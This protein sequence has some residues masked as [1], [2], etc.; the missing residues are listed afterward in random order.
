[1]SCVVI[2][3]GLLY[4]LLL[5]LLSMLLF[6]FQCISASYAL[7]FFTLLAQRDVFYSVKVIAK[8]L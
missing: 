8:L 3:A 1:M 2:Y 4:I 7:T 5:F 6:I